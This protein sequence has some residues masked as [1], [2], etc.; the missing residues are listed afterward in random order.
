VTY[1]DRDGVRIYYRAF[2]PPDGAAPL[3]LTHG[4]SASSAMWQPN[5]AALAAARPVITWDLRGHGS[6]DGPARGLALAARGMLTRRDAHVID[7]LP[8]ITIPA[9][10]L[11][12]AQDKDYL[13]AAGYMAAKLPRAAY[14][15]IPDAGHVCNIDQPD[16][17]SQYVLAFLDQPE[18]RTP[19]L[20][21]RSLWQCSYLA[22]SSRTCATWYGGSWRRNRQSARYGG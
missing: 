19:G 21:P 17:F 15:A 18:L 3:L 16:L 1:L 12:G 22:M 5:I 6:S 4:F 8:A 11:V 9:L 13:A 2:G 20:E 14:A 10:V 7:A